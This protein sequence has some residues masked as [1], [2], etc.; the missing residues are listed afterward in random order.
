MDGDI[1]PLPEIVALARR[2][3]AMILLDDAHATGV[4][5]SQGRGTMEHFQLADETVIQMGTLGKA[6]GTYGA[7][8]AG[9]RALI[10]HLLNTARTFLFTTALPP[11]VA[12]ATIAALEVIAQEP[13]RR[14]RLWENQRQLAAGLRAAGFDLG[15]SE[16]PILPVITGDARRAVEMAT[17]LW[18]AGVWAPAIRPPTVPEGTS[19]IRLAVMATHSSDDLEFALDAVR[20]AGKDTGLL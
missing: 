16:T 5:G 19:R 13:E 6:I 12:A 18:E 9:S 17:R 20:R 1:A 14:K 10:T 3:E 2:H 15:Q 7:Y 4:L 11:A 8:V